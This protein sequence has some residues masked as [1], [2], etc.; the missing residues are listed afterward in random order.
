[1][2]FDVKTFLKNSNQFPVEELAKYE[3]KWIAWSPD[4]TRIVASTTDHEAI[5]DLIQEA[6]ENP[7]LC[8][9][10]YIPEANHADMG[11]AGGPP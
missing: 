11:L 9:V 10:D 4:G 8:L 6:G 7:S 1:V 3:G 2:P 5:L